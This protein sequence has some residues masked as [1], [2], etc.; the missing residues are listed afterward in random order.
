MANL[1]I[2]QLPAVST[3]NPSSL[4]VL[5]QNGSA[6][7]VTADTFRR[8]WIG[9]A[10]QFRPKGKYSTLTALRAAVPNPELGDMYYVG[11][12][13]PYSV[14]AALNIGQANPWV[15]VGAI[16]TDVQTT[17][18][19]IQFPGGVNSGS[20]DIKSFLVGNVTRNI[21]DA[22]AL[23]LTA[24]GDNLPSGAD[25]DDYSTPGIWRSTGAAITQTLVNCPISS[26]TIKLIVSAASS[27]NTYNQLLF[28]SNGFSY[29]R[30]IGTVPSPWL[31][32][33]NAEISNDNLLMNPWFTVNQRGKT[34]YN[35]N[36]YTVDRWITISYTQ[37]V[38]VTANGITIIGSPWF[39]QYFEKSVPLVGKTVTASILLADGTI[40]SGSG[41]VQ[42]NAITSFVTFTVSGI[43]VGLEV[44]TTG[45][46]F[47]VFRIVNYEGNT[48]VTLNIRACKLE[49]GSTST[50]A[51]DVMP[52][53][54]TELTKCKRFFQRIG[55]VG[56]SWQGYGGVNSTP[57]KRLFM[58]IPCAKMRTT[59]VVSTSGTIRCF[60]DIGTA[61]ETE[62]IAMSFA[63][64]NSVTLLVTMAAAL[65]GGK[66]YLLR[67]DSTAYIDLSAEL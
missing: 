41:V 34:S 53:Y 7:K 50:L 47:N 58:T 16:G 36:G 32:L 17:A 12:S 20:G 14:Y 59:P 44:N 42:N 56:T 26:G 9:E 49:Y 31:R 55:G 23:D 35:S 46:S 62:S 66:M 40:Y 60:S 24:P 63:D 38:S 45:S 51:Y 33:D 54:A 15:N 29:I 39:E 27:S 2:N 3:V 61:Y 21:K 11:S 4:F 48:S 67:T 8:Q 57:N 28:A 25:L 22:D 30:N 64:D 13:A 10:N 52:D 1:P 19:Q 65:D 37:T 43:S 5:E 6:S 18:D